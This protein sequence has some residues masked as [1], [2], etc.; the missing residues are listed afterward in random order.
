MKVA[1]NLFLALLATSTMVLVSACGPKAYVKGEYDDVEKENNLNDAWSETDMQKVV[2]DLVSSMNQS[3]SVAQAKFF[4]FPV[5]DSKCACLPR[6][7]I[8]LNN[9]A[10]GD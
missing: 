3:A 10:A 1:K 9:I 8:A 7:H 2:A 6:I 4:Y 5:N